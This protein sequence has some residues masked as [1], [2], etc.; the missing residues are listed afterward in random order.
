MGEHGVPMDKY[1]VARIDE[2]GVPGRD[3]HGVHGVGKH[4]VLQDAL[5]RTDETGS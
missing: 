2:R 1:G 4:G 5:D 3:K